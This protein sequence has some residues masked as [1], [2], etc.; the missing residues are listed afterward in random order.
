MNAGYKKPHEG[1]FLDR[2]ASKS[3]L[4]LGIGLELRLAGRSRD[5][6][7]SDLRLHLRTL[8]LLPARSLR[9]A[10]PLQAGLFPKL[11]AV[12]N[13]ALPLFSPFPRLRT[14]PLPAGRQCCVGAPMLFAGFPF[15][16]PLDPMEIKK[17]SLFPLPLL[18]VLIPF[19]RC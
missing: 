1:E 10:V 9:P 13:S 6:I 18:C 3:C 11:R 16:L 12:L 2:G 17:V 5:F 15:F 19:R 14:S 7:I 8:V 4:P